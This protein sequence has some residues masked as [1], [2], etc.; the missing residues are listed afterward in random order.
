MKQWEYNI[1][2]SL[3]IAAIAIEIAALAKEIAES[4]E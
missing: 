4:Q 3:I 1:L 2:A